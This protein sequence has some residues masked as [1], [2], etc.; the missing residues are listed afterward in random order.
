MLDPVDQQSKESPVRHPENKKSNNSINLHPTD[1]DN[2]EI[3][4]RKIHRYLK[5][6]ISNRRYSNAERKSVNKTG[7]KVIHEDIDKDK[8]SHVSP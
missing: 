3:I 1:V 5:P 6:L 4:R 2:Y 8:D 7:L